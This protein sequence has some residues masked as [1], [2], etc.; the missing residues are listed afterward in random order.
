[1]GLVLVFCQVEEQVKTL[2][3]EIYQLSITLFDSPH[4]DNFELAI[5]TNVSI[6]PL[7]CRPFSITF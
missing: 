2:G 4:P 5:C 6:C 3:F 1:M 7:R